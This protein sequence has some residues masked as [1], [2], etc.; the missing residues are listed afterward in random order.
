LEDKLGA[1]RTAESDLTTQRAHRPVALTPEELAWISSVGADVRAVFN[2]P[3]TTLHERK[4]L[5]R[6][7]SLRSVLPS[8]RNSESLTCGS[9]GRA[10]RPPTCRC[11]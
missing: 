2:A 8:T 6:A 1:V 5:I 9:C 7:R 4:Q 11:R 3:T 10:A